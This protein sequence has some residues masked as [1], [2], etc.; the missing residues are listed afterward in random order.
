MKLYFTL[1]LSIIN[2][3]IFAY[4]IE[5]DSKLN[6]HISQKTILNPCSGSLINVDFGI[7]Q[8]DIE[9]NNTTIIGNIF[10]Q[11]ALRHNESSYLLKNNGF[12]SISI[13]VID[14]DNDMF[15][16]LFY[17]DIPNSSM[18]IIYKIRFQF[19]SNKVIGAT[20]IDMQL[21]KC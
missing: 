14:V 21:A 2:T 1:L 5:T 9:R 12:F 8:F 17:Y 11:M 15:D 3:F 7:I 20:L 4:P 6:L 18:S 13:D 16:S 10:I 19:I